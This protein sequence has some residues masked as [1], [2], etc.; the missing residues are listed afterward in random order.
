MA[1]QVLTI[2]ALSIIALCWAELAYRLFLYQVYGKQ[3]FKNHVNDGYFMT[4]SSICIACVV[5]MIAVAIA[6]RTWT[7]SA[8][9]APTLGSLAGAAYLAALHIAHEHAVIVTYGEWV[10]KYGP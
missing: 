9:I 1:R 7:F 3:P 4:M 10:V 6:R 2:T 5:T 8:L